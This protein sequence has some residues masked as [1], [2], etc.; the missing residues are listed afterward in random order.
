[1][2]FFHKQSAL[3]A[4]AAL[5]AGCSSTP[6]VPTDFSL[7]RASVVAVAGEPQVAV[8]GPGG[9]GSAV[10]KSAGAGGGLGLLITGIACAGAGFLAPVCFATL[11]PTGIAVGALGGAAVGAIRAE[12]A[13]EVDAKRVLLRSVLAASEPNFGLMRNL[14]EQARDLA[15]IQ[16]QKEESAGAAAMQPWTLRLS[17]VELA[18]VGSGAD[19]PYALHLSA[20]LDVDQT[21]G[22]PRVFAKRYQATTTTKMTTS[23]WALNTSEAARAEMDMLLA[24]LAVQIVQ[25]LVPAD[26]LRK[27]RNPTPGAPGSS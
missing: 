1:M 17:V 16:I 14:V 7:A 2:R 22:A 13:D 27:P 3:V 6:R 5:I 11:V 24:A 21:G 25:D 9:K 4:V 10:A 26:K 12:N 20:D 15:D 23:Q 19:A 18:T 8:D